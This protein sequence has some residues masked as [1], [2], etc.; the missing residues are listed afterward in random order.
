MAATFTSYTRRINDL[1]F[2]ISVNLLLVLLSLTRSPSSSLALVDCLPNR[3][4]RPVTDPPSLYGRIR[5]L[6]FVCREEPRMI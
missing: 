2:P 6:H 3:L 5:E 1:N 4:P